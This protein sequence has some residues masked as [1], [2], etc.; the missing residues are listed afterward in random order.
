MHSLN[1]L[2]HMAPMALLML[3]PLVLL[4]GAPCARV[5][6][7]CMHALDMLWLADIC[8]A[9]CAFGVAPEREAPAAA[10]ALAR[11]QPAFL[12]LLALNCAAASAVNLANFLVTRATSALTLQVLGKAKSVI[13]VAASLLIFRN[14]VSV[15]GLT[16]YGICLAGV[17]A[18]GKAK[19]AAA[20]AAGGAH[21]GGGG[22]REGAD[23]RLAP[24]GGGDGE[25]L[26][27]TAHARKP[28]KQTL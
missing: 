13:A 25:A 27:P 11:S 5:V 12:P 9:V 14:K 21:A 17:A 23:A 22:G 16:G 1:L 2:S 7:R 20:A 4:L 28:A 18:Y 8:V 26:L 3:L 6:L 24:Y 10:L 19:A 15:L